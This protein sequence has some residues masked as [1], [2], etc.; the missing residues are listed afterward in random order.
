MTVADTTGPSL[1]TVVAERLGLRWQVH[2]DPFGLGLDALVGLA[3][4]RNPKRAQL[5]VSTVLAKHL[6]ARPAAVR[7]AG[8]LLAALVQQALTGHLPAGLD[9]GLLTDPDRGADVDARALGAFQGAPLVI[10][11]CETATALGHLVADAFTGGDYLHTTRR[12]D[13]RRPVAAGFDEEHSHAVSHVLQPDGPLLDDDRPLILV[14]DELTTGT[15]ALNTLAAL[16]ARSP[17]PAYV[18][19]ALL[20]LRPE[21]AR[22]AFR[23]RVAALGVPVTVVALLDGALEVPDDALARAAGLLATEATAATEPTDQQAPTTT[24]TAWPRGV[25]T[26]GRHGFRSTDREAFTR[27]LDAAVSALT[28]T[29]RGPVLVVGTEELMYAPVRVAHALELALR[30]TGSTR[31]VRVQ[32]TTRSPVVPLDVPGYAIRRRLVTTSPD[33]PMRP[34]FLYNLTPGYDDIVVVTEDP[35]HRS[36]GLLE[37]LRPWARSGVH[38]LVL[39]SPDVEPR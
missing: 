12:P 15:T 21:A 32:S 35:A 10:G 14:D 31:D 25:P 8:L 17:R 33:D 1:G 27:A 2:A 23:S 37:A 36:A 6:P 3:V 26:G 39:D 4:R 18:V 11:F 7:A 22:T 29:G 28:L 19:A 24:V 9:G 34:S 38:L 13:S 20:D 30:R 16:H 5:V